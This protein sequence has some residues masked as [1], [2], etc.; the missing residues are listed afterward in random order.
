M[1]LC[2]SIQKKQRMDIEI[3][4]Y[5]DLRQGRV[6]FKEWKIRHYYQIDK[7]AKEISSKLSLLEGAVVFTV[8]KVL[9]LINQFIFI[10][11]QFKRVKKRIEK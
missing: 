4:L 7:I 8:W 3:Q 6:L 10:I 9:Y 1:S 2:L 11:I 5:E